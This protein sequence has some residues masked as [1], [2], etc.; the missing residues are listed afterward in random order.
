MPTKGGQLRGLWFVAAEMGERNAFIVA[1]G[2]NEEQVFVF[3][4]RQVMRPT[5]A[6]DQSAQHLA[7]NRAED[8][9]VRELNDK[10]A[11]RLSVAQLH[12]PDVPVEQVPL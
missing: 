6:S 2:T 11:P 3:P 10:D 5:P 9:A 4:V 8:V 7:Q 12:L 1:R